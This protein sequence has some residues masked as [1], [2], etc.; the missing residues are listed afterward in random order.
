MVFGFFSFQTLPSARQKTLGKDGFADTFLPSEIC[1]AL[2]SAN[3]GFACESGSEPCMESRGILKL[4]TNL[5]LAWMA[6]AGVQFRSRMNGC[7]HIYWEICYWEILNTEN[8]GILRDTKKWDGV[9]ST[10]DI[11]WEILNTKNWHTPRD[12][13]K[14]DGIL[15]K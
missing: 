12:T 8:W 1:G 13:E 14:Q 3:C 2:H 4:T 7:A 5:V 9:K 6:V 10:N 11:Y 15:H